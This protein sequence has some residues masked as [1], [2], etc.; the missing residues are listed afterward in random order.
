MSA[1]SRTYA[2]AAKA[3]DPESQ[4]KDSGQARLE[5]LGYQQ[6][7][8]RRF[9]LLSSA[10]SSFAVTSYMMSLTGNRVV[11]QS[12]KRPDNRTCMPKV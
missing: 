9:G 3:N 6:V 2:A 4:E 10:G 1:L 11:L 12:Q 7:L 8:S 5:A